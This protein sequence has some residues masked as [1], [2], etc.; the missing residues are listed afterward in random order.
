MFHN[1]QVHTDCKV[2]KLCIITKRNFWHAF[3]KNV[4]LC[5]SLIEKQKEKP[6]TSLP[7]FPL[8]VGKHLTLKTQRITLHLC[9]YK[10]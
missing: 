7:R 5:S 2:R 1:I 3:K 9:K 6:P 4:H 10:H 8:P